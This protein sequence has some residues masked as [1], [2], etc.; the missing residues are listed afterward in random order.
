MKNICLISGF[1]YRCVHFH[2]RFPNSSVALYDKP[3]S[4]CKIIHQPLYW[5]S[6]ETYVNSKPYKE[7]S[8]IV[9]FAP[10]FY[11]SLIFTTNELSWNDA[12]KTCDKHNALL[13]QPKNNN[14]L[15]RVFVKFPDDNFFHLGMHLENDD[16][17]TVHGTNVT[18]FFWAEE[19]PNSDGSEKCGGAQRNGTEDID[20]D[21]DIRKGIC[22]Y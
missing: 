2:A 1:N 20:C 16:W 10:N 5:T 21:K 19:E 3:T 4:L 17:I 15:E 6:K 8:N 7:T 9:A 18:K 14:F 22:V 12:K 13:L 11:H